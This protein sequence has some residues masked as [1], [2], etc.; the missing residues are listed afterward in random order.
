MNNILK[1]KSLTIILFSFVIIICII[2]ILRI[3]AI[4]E[5]LVLIVFSFILAYTLKPMYSLLIKKGINSKGAALTLIIGVLLFV[6]LIFIVLIPSIFKEGLSF[7][8]SLKEFEEYATSFHMKLRLLRNNKIVYGVLNT[9][10]KK[11][12]S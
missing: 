6:L 5:I 8:D 1:N 3:E 12:N 7:T 4:K 11:L 2:F 9:V 10:Y